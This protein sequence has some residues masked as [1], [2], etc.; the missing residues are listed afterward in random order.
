MAPTDAQRRA[1]KKWQ[2]EKVDDIRF[3]APK[4]KRKEIRDHAESQGETMNSFLNRAVTET[5]E[6]DQKKSD[7]NT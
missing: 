7:D 2:A 3:R 5:M 6:R 1:S 4:G